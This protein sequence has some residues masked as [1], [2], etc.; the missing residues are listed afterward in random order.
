M[1]LPFC[2]ASC[3]S[4]PEWSFMRRFK[5]FLTYEKPIRL[6]QSVMKKGGFVSWILPKRT[7]AV[8]PV[9]ISVFVLT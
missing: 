7:N 2:N 8:S 6:L 4:K 1:A 3:N 9:H 5:T